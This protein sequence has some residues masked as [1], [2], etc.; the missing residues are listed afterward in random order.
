[1]EIGMGGTAAK[2]AEA[3]ANVYSLVLTDGRRS[4]NPFHLERAALASLRKQEAEKAAA[5]LGVAETIFCDLED[6]KA[7]EN[8]QTAKQRLCNQIERFPPSEIYTLHPELDR[9]RTHQLAG[10]IVV[11]TVREIQVNC[12][13]WAY[14]VWGL[15][16][17][18]DRFEDISSTIGKKIRAIGEHKSQIASIPYGEGVAG[19]NRWRAIFSDPLQ[20]EQSC[21]FAEVFLQMK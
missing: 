4:P 1:M 9:H 8:Y 6:L 15:F 18:W 3:G 2:L 13:L 5:I 10:K 7:S 16:E 11:E 21:A 12:A 19:L 20:N 14:E 17:R